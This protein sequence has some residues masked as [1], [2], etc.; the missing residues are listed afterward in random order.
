MITIS[1]LNYATG[2]PLQ[3]RSIQ[4]IFTDT[5]FG[6]IRPKITDEGGVTQVET[7]PG[8]ARVYVEGEFFGEYWLQENMEISLK[9]AGDTEPDVEFIDLNKARTQEQ[10]PVKE[11]GVP[12]SLI[13]LES[14]QE[15]RA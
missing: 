4:L 11:Q 5:V 3:G 1:L 10:E 13:T 12:T 15:V 8:P 14:E 9:K 2:L 6:W 7:S